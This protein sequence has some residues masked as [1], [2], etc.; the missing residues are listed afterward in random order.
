M[1]Y[2]KCLVIC[3]LKILVP[4]DI[5]T[6]H[7]SCIHSNHKQMAWTLL[8]KLSQRC[9]N[10]HI[11]P[12]Q[13]LHATLETHIPQKT[14]TSHRPLDL[15]WSFEKL[16]VLHII[17]LLII[18]PSTL[19]QGLGTYNQQITKTNNIINMHLG[20]VYLQPTNHNSSKLKT[21]SFKFEVFLD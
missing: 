10:K 17:P 16:K 4:I 7:T 2:C 5:W 13:T 18:E 20:L 21:I 12:S 6:S 14:S 15:L 3:K 11:G 9:I 1:T 8:K 19:A